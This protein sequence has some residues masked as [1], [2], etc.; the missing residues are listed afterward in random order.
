MEIK[1][2]AKIAGIIL[3]FSHTDYFL[4]WSTFDSVARIA[5]L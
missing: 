3:S 2:A 1:E 4:D 5:V